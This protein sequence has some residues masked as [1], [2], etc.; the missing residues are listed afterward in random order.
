MI[1]AAELDFES[2]GVE[3]GC[4]LEAGEVLLLSTSL[5]TDR[6]FFHSRVVDRLEQSC[7]VRI[8]TTAAR[9]GDPRSATGSGSAEVE[10][11]PRILPFREFPYNYLRRLNEF[12]WDFSLRP[13]SRLSMMRHVRNGSQRAHVRA[14]KAPA[15]LVA[16]I[17]AEQRLE[18]GLETLLLG[19]ERSPEAT[20]RL[21]ALGPAVVVTTGPFQFEQP[22]VVAAARRLGIPC[23][24]LIP[25][26][27]NLSTK[28]RMVLRYDGFIVWSEVAKRELREFYPY[29]H[30][31]P[32]YVV[33][34]PQFDSFF[35]E[36]FRV[37][38]AEFCAS[39]GLRPELPVIV[40]A[41][42][43]PNFLR[44]HFAALDL[45]RSVA[46]GDLG[47]A[48]LIVRPH[49]IHDYPTIAGMLEKTHSGI[50]VQRTAVSGTPIS[51]RYQD[52]RQMVEWINTFRHADVVVNLA[53][54][55]TIDAAIFDRPTVSLDYD[56]EPGSPNA[57]LVR[58]VNHVWSHFKPVAESGGVWLAR[59]R[60]DLTDAIRTYLALPELHREGRKWVARHVCEYLDGRS[61]ERMARA[62]RDF[63][64][65]RERLE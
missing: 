17:G 35:D 34:A 9:E 33:G 47:G 12:V 44:E 49:P 29:S 54:T 55:A 46:R 64:Q 2:R 16:M 31:V 13:P 39:Q 26:W 1:E 56:P 53:S 62:I 60:A 57:A 45:A 7:R 43:S 51:A 32:V 23:L 30:G 37:S 65:D 52:R 36:S 25:S 21:G 15:R 6:M 48:Q 22:A 14:L 42:G 40:Y 18:G 11:F 20:E 58:D 50:V 63:V 27:D 5:L 59:D 19:Y 61:G 3:R 4:E 38:R 10:S 8:W 28:N 24:A 41:L